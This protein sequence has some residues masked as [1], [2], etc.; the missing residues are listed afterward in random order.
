MGSTFHTGF[1]MAQLRF[2]PYFPPGCICRFASEVGIACRSP[3]GEQAFK[4]RPVI[5]LDLCVLA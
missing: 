5:D 3:A 4:A 2:R 1:G